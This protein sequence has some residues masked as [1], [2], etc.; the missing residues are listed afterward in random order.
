[1]LACKVKGNKGDYHLLVGG[2]EH[3]DFFHSVWNVIIPTDE[4]HHFS[5]W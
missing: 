1:M 4:L 2:L 5:E 3:L